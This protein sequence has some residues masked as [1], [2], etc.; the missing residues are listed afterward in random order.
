MIQLLSI[1]AEGPPSLVG[2]RP[3][4]ERLFCLDK[5]HILSFLDAG[6]TFQDRGAFYVCDFTGRRSLDVLAE[7]DY[8]PPAVN[9]TV[10]VPDAAPEIQTIT[11][12]C[13]VRLLSFVW[14]SV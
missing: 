11:F 9:A 13:H 10:E 14:S 4:K 3:I 2:L 1:D 5:R 6:F 7:F 12:S 8:I